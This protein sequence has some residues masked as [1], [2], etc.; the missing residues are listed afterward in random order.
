MLLF[1][2]QYCAFRDIFGITK[3]SEPQSAEDD[4]QLLA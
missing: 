4:S 1:A 3:G 2:T